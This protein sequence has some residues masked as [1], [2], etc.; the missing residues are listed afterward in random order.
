MNVGLNAVSARR[1]GNRVQVSELSDK[2]VEILVEASRQANVEGDVTRASAYKVSA[3]K[4]FV[5]S[6]LLFDQD[7]SGP[8]GRSV[9]EV[10]RSI[11]A[12]NHVL[13]KLRDW[14]GAETRH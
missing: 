11:D 4:V 13:E 8:G 12:L 14:L 7:G 3:A 9:D 10:R 6:H 2:V 5:A 1:G